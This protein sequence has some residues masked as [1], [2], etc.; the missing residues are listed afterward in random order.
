GLIACEAPD[1]PVSIADAERFAHGLADRLG[2]DVGC[3]VPAYED[4]ATYLLEEHGLPINLE[5]GDAR[6]GDPEER[7]RLARVFDRGL[8]TPAGFVLPLQRWQ[9]R[10]GGGWVSERWALRRERLGLRPRGSP[11]GVPP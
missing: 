4:P 1:R 8:G 10:A 7:A 11:P 9:A 5:P 2:V 3:V 6:L